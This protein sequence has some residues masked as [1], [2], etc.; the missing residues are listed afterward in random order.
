[1]VRNN[2]FCLSVAQVIDKDM[3]ISIFTD[4]DAVYL[5]DIIISVR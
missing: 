4:Y 2:P 1:M 3:I 5:D